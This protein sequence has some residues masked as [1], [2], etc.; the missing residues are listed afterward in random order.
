MKPLLISLFIIAATCS[1]TAQKAY[2]CS[3]KVILTYDVQLD[4]GE[5]V[6]N[7]IGG[8]LDIRAGSD[9][10]LVSHIILHGL[11]DLAH[12]Q[13]GDIYTRIPTK[14][15][16]YNNRSITVNGK[17]ETVRLLH[18]YKDISLDI[19]TKEVEVAQANEFILY[20]PSGA[21]AW[22]NHGNLLLDK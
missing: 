7:V 3:M 6:K 9:I 14:S 15:F 2:N 20:T 19:A 12:D 5:I 11:L 13:Y 22:E 8:Y 18:N 10:K 1:L 16:L 17:L 4:S 21:R